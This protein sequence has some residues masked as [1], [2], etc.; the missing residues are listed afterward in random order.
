MAI[1]NLLGK[2]SGK[3]AAGNS[4]ENVDTTNK[5]EKTS[6]TNT[7]SSGSVVNSIDAK[8]HHSDHVNDDEKPK[9]KIIS[10]LLGAIASMGGL[11]F[12]YESGQISGFTNESDFIARFGQNGAFSAARQGTIVGLLAIGA[13]IGC[14]AS[15]WIADK[16]GRKYT[17]AGS[18]FFYCIGVVIEVTSTTHWVQFAMGRFT[19]GLGIG[20]L[21]TTVPMYQTESV[22]RNIRSMVVASYQLM[23]TI[24][25]W[26]AYM[27]N[28]GTSSQYTNSAQWRIPNALSALWAILLGV[29]ILFMPESPRYLYRHDKQDQAR[30]IIARLA[31]VSPDALVVREEI[32]EIEEKHQEEITAGK[33]PWTE[34]FTGPGMLHR[35]LLG[36]TLQA[37]QQ[38]TG[39]NFF[40]YYGT[41][42]F[43]ATGISN[44]FV[45]S[46]ILGTVN[47]VATVAGL[48]VVKVCNRRSA[49]MFGAAWMCMCFLIFSFVGHYQLSATDPASTPQAGNIMIVFTCLFICAFATTWGPMVWS[50]VGELYPIQ[51]RAICMALATSCNW[52]FNFL[53]SFFSTFITDAIDY[54]YG[55]VFAGSCAALFF[56]VYF[57]MIETKGRSM[58]EVDWM[59]A[60]G[61]SPIGSEKWDAAAAKQ[62]R[63]EKRHGDSSK[64]GIPEAMFTD[65]AE[66]AEA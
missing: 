31:G 10:V 20:A 24:G 17:I 60:G 39:A 7:P 18:A 54:F 59:Y 14:L 21:S 56:I 30:N 28:F 9:V 8:T 43:Q 2:L 49:L 55:L 58:E 3:K 48:W 16:A 63:A 45:T 46:I 62:V 51:Y 42:I 23:I 15:G 35:T 27:I 25:I 61:V 4:P 65:H 11:V 13:L 38:M 5:V 47:V 34:I 40:F 33:R 64:S 53:I 19:T 66:A 26:L 50:Q 6:E 57:F 12:G 22:P 32:A 1:Q 41:T 37:G 44:S 29:G 52:L 36:M